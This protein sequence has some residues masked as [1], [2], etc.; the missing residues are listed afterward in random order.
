M[1]DSIVDLATV[2]CEEMILDDNFMD[3]LRDQIMNDDD[4]GFFNN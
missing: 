3:F 1:D 4:N 2:S